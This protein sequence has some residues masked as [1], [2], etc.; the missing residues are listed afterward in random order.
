MIERARYARSADLDA[1][2]VGDH[3]TTPTNYLQNSPMLGRLLAQW[4][5][6]PAGALY[7]LP[8][9]H[10]VLLAE[11]IG[12]LAAIA[13]GPFIMQCGLGGDK[14]QAR[15]MG[16]SFSHRAAMFEASLNLLRALWRGE[17]VSESRF[18]HID[19]ARVNPLPTDAVDVWVGAAVPRALARTARLADG[20]LASPAL[21]IAA[22]RDDLNRYRQA[23]A[24]H[25]TSPRAVALRR[26]IYI[27]ATAAEAKKTVQPYLAAGYRGFDGSALCYGSIEQVA[28][29]F[30]EFAS[31]G[32]TDI[33]VRNISTK[34]AE[35]LATIER[36]G[37]V[38]K[39]VGRV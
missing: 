32:Y 25:N 1:L 6:R 12:T 36:L 9:W 18:W 7:L 38:R 37:E 4:G 29:Q 31:L 14:R 21:T 19:R 16:T 11:Q 26:D 10:P 8:L 27:G 20:W 17:T 34:Q 28:Q 5:D 3:H 24:E 15:G 33:I 13:E 35:A 39:L 2:F 22:A 30:L 23:C